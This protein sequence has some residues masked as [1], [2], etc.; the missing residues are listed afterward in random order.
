MKLCYSVQIERSYLIFICRGKGIPKNIQASQGKIKNKKI[1]ARQVTLKYS[2]TG[3][4]KIL[5]R[6][7]LTKNFMRHGNSSCPRMTEQIQ[8]QRRLECISRDLK[9]LWIA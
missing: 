8:I 1:Y 7:I 4:E 2:C 5:T 6:K 9:V 3:L